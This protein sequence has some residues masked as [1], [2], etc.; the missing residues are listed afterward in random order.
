MAI[1]ELEFRRILQLFPV[2]RSRDYYL[3]VESSG[4]S[5]SRSTGDKEATKWQGGDRIDR[6]SYPTD[7]HDA[8][9]DKLKAAAEKKVGPTEA[10]KI[11]KAFQ[12]VYKRLVYEELSLEAAQ[13]FINSSGNPKN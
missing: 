10:E 1:D 8:F 4:P 2:V 9:W 6:D 3:D 12:Q 13:N 11:C 7:H 5:T